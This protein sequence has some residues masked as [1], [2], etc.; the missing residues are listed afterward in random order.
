MK[1]NQEQMDLLQNLRNEQQKLENMGPLNQR[2][3]HVDTT[4]DFM[5]TQE[6]VLRMN[7]IASI[8]GP[9]MINFWLLL[10]YTSDDENDKVTHY[11]TSTES[12]EML[13]I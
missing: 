13:T 7:Q 1:L 6:R 11:V 8:L 3:R 9:W 5:S 12:L 10:I 4:Q 2:G